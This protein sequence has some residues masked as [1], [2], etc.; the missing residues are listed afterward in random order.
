MNN[1]EHLYESGKDIANEIEYD[2][3]LAWLGNPT[4]TIVGGPV[5]TEDLK[6]TK[7]EFN[8]GCV[9]YTMDRKKNGDMMTIHI[10]NDSWKPTTCNLDVGDEDDEKIEPV[11]LKC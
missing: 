7:A 3:F 6:M 8:N 4:G 1:A 11:I 5:P 9:N 2:K 10:K